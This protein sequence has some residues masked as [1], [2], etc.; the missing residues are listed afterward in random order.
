MPGDYRVVPFKIDGG[1]PAPNGLPLVP[2]TS[3]PHSATGNAT[4]LGNYTTEG[5]TF[6][7]GSLQISPT[8]VVSGTFQGSI[9]FVAANGDKLAVNYGVG[10]TGTFTG[11]LS[12]DGTA[13]TNVTFTAFFTPDPTNSTG[14]FADVVGGGWLMIAHAD[15]ISLMSTTPGYTAKFD[16]TWSGQGTLEYAK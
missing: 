3:G 14:R 13:V 6:T 4:E 2:G 12:S 15:S 16:Y 1:G 5:G 8:G 9:V 10:D 7:L 11:Q